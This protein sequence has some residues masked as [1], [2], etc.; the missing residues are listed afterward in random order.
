MVTPRIVFDA[1]CL[2]GAPG[3]V[4][5]YAAALVHHLPKLAPNI[6][7]VFLRHPDARA[8]LSTDP[9][10]TEWSLGGDPNDPISYLRVGPWLRRRLRPDDLFHAPYRILPLGAPPQSV[11]TIHDVMQIVCP[12]L[13]FPNPFV[14]TLL[15]PYWGMAIRSSLHRAGRIIAVSN[16]SRDDA[17]RL[18]PSCKDRIRVT[19]LA[20]EPVFTRPDDEVAL[21]NTRELVP[22]GM[23]FFLVLGGG[24]PN[25]NHAAAVLAFAAAFSSADDVHLVIIQRERTFSKEVEIALRET[26]L[27]DRVHV[28]SK[29]SM[30]ALVGLYARAEALVFPSLYEGFGLPVLEAM[31]CGCPVVCSTLTSVPEVAGDAALLCDPRDLDAL[32]KA[33]R[34]VA[35]DAPLRLDLRARGLLRARQFRWEQTAKQTLD[36]YRELVPS[37]P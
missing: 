20:A 26:G 3:G 19:Y 7:F 13:V 8:P 9:N 37:L 2:R 10:V 12:E 24:Y 1:R 29:I 16:H 33:L 15:A 17:A 6:E 22:A 5:T 18:I 32:A 27:A 34:R 35:N 36:T 31:S 28:R 23:R 14:R 21:E 4:A 30:E 11:I 25:K